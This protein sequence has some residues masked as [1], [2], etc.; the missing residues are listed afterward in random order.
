MQVELS[1]NYNTL[2]FEVTRLNHELNVK[3]NDMTVFV[4][5]INGYVK[6]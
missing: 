1:F 6:H 4:K 3:L 2:L 5:I